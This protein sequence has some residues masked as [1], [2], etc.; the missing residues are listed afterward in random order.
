MASNDENGS[1][2]DPGKSFNDGCMSTG[3]LEVSPAAEAV[4]EHAD[5][6]DEA[7]SVVELRRQM[8]RRMTGLERPSDKVRAYQNGIE[9][10][11]YDKE[12]SKVV[13]K[14][15]AFANEEQLASEH[16]ALVARQMV[17]SNC[18]LTLQLVWHQ[19]G[20]RRQYVLMDVAASIR[21]DELTK[22]VQR[23]CSR[24][25][26][27]R[28]LW[29]HPDGETIE[30]DK[31]ST[32]DE[33]VH[34]MWA[35]QPWVIHVHDP[36]TLHVD[37]IAL[38][39]KAAV[40][41][42]RYDLNGNGRVE[43]RELTRLFQDLNLEQLEC[44]D[45]LIQEFIE[46]EFLRLDKDSSGGLTLSEFTTYPQRLSLEPRAFHTMADGPTGPIP[47]AHAFRRYTTS[48]SRW[49]RK[50]LAWQANEH[51][52]FHLLASRTVEVHRPPA[53]VEFGS[54]PYDIPP[55]K[56]FTRWEEMVEAPAAATPE[57]PFVVVE[58][59]HFGIRVEVP[60]GA[61]NR[62]PLRCH[63]LNLSAKL[64]IQTHAPGEV[65]HLSANNLKTH[66]R[67][68]GEF[69]FS[70]IVRASSNAAGA[71]PCAKSHP[72]RRLTLTRLTA[73]PARIWSFAFGVPGALFPQH[74]HTPRHTA[75]AAAG[76][77]PGAL[78]SL[79]HLPRSPP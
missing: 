15:V 31:Q 40:L 76:L 30:L 34:T 32:F 46:G 21:L 51:N 71:R 62:H 35:V 57:M 63:P 25:N 79:D 27:L 48:M 52:V 4:L 66:G 59:G 5:Q 2:C 69:L 45:A 1:C 3:D 78:T 43:A 53:P 44:S 70:P 67:K 24:K 26:P 6:A 23:R 55:Q 33:Y 54:I 22:A 73:P 9:A 12:Y 60:F 20:A 13:H 68:L 49:M 29:L 8:S 58:A 74:P 38:D 47:S 56:P 19:R 11:T 10:A 36:L 61:L 72:G 37:R 14:A 42:D 39:E 16:Q 41:F 77:Q 18:Q 65:S 7:Y 50:E 75:W 28:L 17:K 64:A